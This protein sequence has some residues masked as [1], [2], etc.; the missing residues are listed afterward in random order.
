MYQPWD[1]GNLTLMNEIT[2]HFAP[3]HI[4]FLT[5]YVLNSL[6]ERALINSHLLNLHFK[7]MVFEQTYVAKFII[8]GITT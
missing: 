4:L 7:F 6:N 8:Y 3:S 1:Q 2:L 5:S